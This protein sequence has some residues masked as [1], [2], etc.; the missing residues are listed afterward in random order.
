MVK[1]FIFI[2]IS[3][4]SV[5]SAFSQDV[6]MINDSV[7]N[8]ISDGPYVFIEQ[9][10]LIEKSI[11]NGEVSS[12]ILNTSAYETVFYPEKS[13]FDNVSDIAAL[14]DIHGQYD[15]AI[16]LLINNNIIDKKLNWNFGKGHLVIVGDVFDRGDKVNEV[17]WLI[18]KLENQA[19]AKGGRVHFLLG[20]HEFMVLHKD[21]RYINQKYGL[22]SKLLNLEYDELYNDKTVIGRW[23][24]SKPTIIKINNT[25]FTHGGVS[26]DFITQS[27]FNIEKIND[28]MRQSIGQSK[29][30]MKATNFYNLYYGSNS[31]IWYR[32]YFNDNLKDTDISE[33]LEHV[34]SEHIVVG[35]CSNKEVVQLF[36]YKIFGVDSS[37]KNGKYGEVLFI[38]N[39]DYS[40][41]TLNGKKKQFNKISAINTIDD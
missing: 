39:N 3:F 26:K 18:Y 14:S 36:N 5:I 4:I 33:I 19:K 24:R 6:E 28:I 17:L 16:E 32:G 29:E 8:I 35:H 21:L 13:I 7:Q 41:G 9:D 1:K 37:I 20:N 22:T 34:N 40:R 2:T 12:N 38:N 31:L 30:D 23:L 10:K 27:D 25:I 11:I 15:L